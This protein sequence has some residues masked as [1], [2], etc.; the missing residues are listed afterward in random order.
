MK[1]FSVIAMA[2]LLLAFNT[3][4]AAADP[5]RV[6]HKTV[7]V[8]RDVVVKPA[9]VRTAVARVT[10]A[11]LRSLPAG[12]IR[13]VHAGKTYYFHDGVY[14]VRE[15]R[16]FVVVKPVRGLRITSLPRGYVTVRVGNEV[17]YRYRDV[18]YRRVNGV[19]VVV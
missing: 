10:T 8:E 3:Q 9:P 2:G 1:R 12:H 5:V 14:Y 7:V 18:S 19:F 13:L 6:V 15:P 11:A 16:G 4:V 17:H